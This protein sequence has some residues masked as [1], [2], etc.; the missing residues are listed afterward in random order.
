MIRYRLDVNLAR[1]SGLPEDSV[2]GLY[3][4]QQSNNDLEKMEKDITCRCQN[5]QVA[6]RRIANMLGRR[7]QTHTAVNRIALP[8]QTRTL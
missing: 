3:F 6:K 4:P 2:L 1:I 5:M 7:F 8:K